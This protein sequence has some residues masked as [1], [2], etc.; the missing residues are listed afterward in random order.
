MTNEHVQKAAQ[1]MAD[2]YK[3]G[4]AGKPVE[5][6]DTSHTTLE[7]Q[8]LLGKHHAETGKASEFARPYGV[9]A[10]SKVEESRAAHG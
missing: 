5:Q 7:Q 8:Y 2:A 3:A 9:S 10:S 4:Y 6:V 1:L